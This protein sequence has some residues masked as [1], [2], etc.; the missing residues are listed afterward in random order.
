MARS[1]MLSMRLMASGVQEASFTR[2]G[3]GFA[4]ISL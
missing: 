3:C 4:C 2:C 1:V